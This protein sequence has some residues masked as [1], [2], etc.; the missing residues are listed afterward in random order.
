LVE[1]T[2]T[3]LEGPEEAAIV[4]AILK[5]RDDVTGWEDLGDD[6]HKVVDESKHAVFELVNEFFQSKLLAIQEVAEFLEEIKQ[7]EH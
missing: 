7:E 6:W 4:A 2:T 3:V 1:S 5:L